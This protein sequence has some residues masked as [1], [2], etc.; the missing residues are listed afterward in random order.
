MAEL[1][2]AVEPML[3]SEA[4]KGI[5][6]SFCP[7][8]TVVR[9]MWQRKWIWGNRR[10]ACSHMERWPPQPLSGLLRNKRSFLLVTTHV[11]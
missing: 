7:K 3:G 2:K 8:S 6:L 1:R 11:K 10:G 4:L 5:K 9:T